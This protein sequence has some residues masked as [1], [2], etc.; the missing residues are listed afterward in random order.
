MLSTV[1]LMRQFMT[2]KRSIIIN[3]IKWQKLHLIYVYIH[4]DY[5]CILSKFIKYSIPLWLFQA[6]SVLFISPSFIS[7]ALPSLSLPN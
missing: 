1:V 3:H 2:L 4:R 5:I 7:S 6:S